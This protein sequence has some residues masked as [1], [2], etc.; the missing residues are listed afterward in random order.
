VYDLIVIVVVIVIIK[1]IF[2]FSSFIS[3]GAVL[4][5]GVV[6]NFTFIIIPLSSFLL[7]IFLVFSFAY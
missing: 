4:K 1:I 6:L 3:Q 7:L 5:I 2:S